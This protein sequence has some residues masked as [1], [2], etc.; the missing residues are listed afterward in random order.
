MFLPGYMYMFHMCVDVNVGS[1]TGRCSEG[2]GGSPPQS[3]GVKSPPPVG[4][5]ISVVKII[6]PRWLLAAIM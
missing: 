1:Q 4:S 5:P 6:I 2:G 3:N